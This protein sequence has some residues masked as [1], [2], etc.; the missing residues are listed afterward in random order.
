[1]TTD[2]FVD[3]NCWSF[4]LSWAGSSRLPGKGLVPI[5]QASLP[6]AAF[7]FIIFSLSRLTSS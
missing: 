2:S 5:Q 4:S 1:M 3:A 6:H 7:L